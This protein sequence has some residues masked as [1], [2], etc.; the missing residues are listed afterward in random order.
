VNDFACAK[1][2]SLINQFLII[3][4]FKF[5]YFIFCGKWEWCFPFTCKICWHDAIF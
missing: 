3:L 1:T 2:V 5:N 4:N